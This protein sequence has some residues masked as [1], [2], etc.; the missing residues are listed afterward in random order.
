MHDAWYWCYFF[1]VY[2]QAFDNSCKV[3]LRSNSCLCMGVLIASDR[4]NSFWYWTETFSKYRSGMFD[5]QNDIFLKRYLTRFSIWKYEV[6]KN[7]VPKIFFIKSIVHRSTWNFAGITKLSISMT[8]W[9]ACGQKRGMS[10]IWVNLNFSTVYV[11][12]SVSQL[13]ITSQFHCHFNRL[14]QINW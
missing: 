10:R 3:K 13:E 9:S 1:S 14:S 8:F 12:Q 11:H 7:F 4:N 2:W 5:F 6:Q